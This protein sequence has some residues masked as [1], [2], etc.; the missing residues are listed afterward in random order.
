MDRHLYWTPI[1]AGTHAIFTGLESA[2]ICQF[3]Q[4]DPVLIFTLSG[5][6][7]VLLRRVVIPGASRMIS[8]TPTI[9]A[10]QDDLGSPY[11]FMRGIPVLRERLETA[12]INGLESDRNSGSHASRR[13]QAATKRA[14][15]SNNYRGD[16]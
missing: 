2:R 14:R 10:E 5:A 9:R 16:A 15:G 11:V 12:A 4:G 13:R 3:G 1:G 7:D 8:L 6:P